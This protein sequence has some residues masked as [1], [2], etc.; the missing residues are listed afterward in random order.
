MKARPKEWKYIVNDEFL[1]EEILATIREIFSGED[2]GDGIRIYHNIRWTNRR[3]EHKDRNEMLSKEICEKIHK[4]CHARMRKYLQELAPLKQGLVDYE[5]MHVVLTGSTAR[6]PVHYDNAEK[7]LS[8]VVY[9][10][11]MHS[12]GTGVYWNNR[13]KIRQIEWKRNR[14][15]IFSRIRGVTWHDYKGGGNGT[16]RLCL[17]YN[18]MTTRSRLAQLLEIV[19]LL[20]RRL[21]LIRQSGSFLR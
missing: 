10:E 8:C 19:E 16:N 11:P 21:R 9:I 7:L 12:A 2:L 4:A 3:C 1:D 15:F 14:A 5:E 13:E 6:F 18:L 17:V 20:G